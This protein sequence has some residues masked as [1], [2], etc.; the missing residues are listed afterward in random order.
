MHPIHRLRAL[1]P[2]QAGFCLTQTLMHVS[3]YALRGYYIARVPAIVA[4]AMLGELARLFTFAAAVARDAAH[5]LLEILIL[6]RRYPV[7]STR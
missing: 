3:T 6:F 4:Y 1:V 7:T 5:G 2:P